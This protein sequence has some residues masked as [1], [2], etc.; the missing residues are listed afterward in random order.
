M[1]T[2]LPTHMIIGLVGLYFLIGYIIALVAI[3]IVKKGIKMG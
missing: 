3:K 2:E 1:M